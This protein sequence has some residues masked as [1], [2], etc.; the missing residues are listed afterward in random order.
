M[1]FHTVRGLV[2][3]IDAKDEYTRGHS[4]RVHHVSILIAKRLGLSAEEIRRVSWAAM[5]HDVGKIAIGR[6]I[7]H[8]PGK[9]TDDEYE[10]IKTHPVRGCRVLEPIPQLREILPGIR[11]HHE[12]WDG[13]GYPD[14]L[15]GEEIPLTSRIIAIADTF[16]AIVSTR[17]YREARS[18]EFA[19]EEI[20]RN[21]GIQFDAQIVPVFLALAA[22]NAFAALNPA[23][24][25]PATAVL[26]P[27]SAPEA[28]DERTAA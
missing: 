7:L 6:S 5:L 22:E 21:A 17:A 19:L 28:E 18:L 26:D 9:L 11:H 15:R 25:T 10:T 3:A 4:E 20:G 12:R 27:L 14:G 16:D 24:Q 23:S 2:A 13:R 8:K 1:L